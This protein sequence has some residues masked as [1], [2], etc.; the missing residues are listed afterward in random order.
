MLL[1]LHVTGM[2]ES[3]RDRYV[4]RLEVG[5]IGDQA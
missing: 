1:G 4:E 2:R 5:D 3:Q